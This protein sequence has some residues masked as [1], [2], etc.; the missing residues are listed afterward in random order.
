VTTEQEFLELQAKRA[1]Q[2]FVEELRG[3]GRDLADPLD[4]RPSVRRRPFTSVAV[5]LA[6]GVLAGLGLGGIRWRG[7]KARLETRLAERRARRQ[8]LR[9]AATSEAREKPRSWAKTIARVRSLA[10]VALTTAA[11]VRGQSHG[12]DAAATATRAAA[13]DHV[14]AA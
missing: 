7:V 4:P 11:L 3:L 5:S 6:A 8:Q 13:D 9:G 12:T 2:R 1:K 10:R 14:P